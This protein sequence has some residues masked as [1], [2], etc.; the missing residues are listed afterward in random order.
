MKGSDSLKRYCTKKLEVLM[1]DIYIEFIEMEESEI[2]L[3]FSLWEGLK[4]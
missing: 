1:N 2:I 4:E 3:R